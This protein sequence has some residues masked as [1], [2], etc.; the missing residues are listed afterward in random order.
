MRSSPPHPYHPIP[1]P[2]LVPRLPVTAA[3]PAS[4]PRRH[5][6]P[7]VR[8]RPRRRSLRDCS[9]SRTAASL[10]MPRLRLVRRR[11]T[12]SAPP[13]PWTMASWESPSRA[14]ARPVSPATSPTLSGG[15]VFETTMLTSTP[16]M[17]RSAKGRRRSADPDILSR[18]WFASSA[19]P[20][21]A[22]TLGPVASAFSICALVRQWRQHRPPGTGVADATFVTDPPW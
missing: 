17:A 3:G 14:R 16:G 5:P 21:I 13:P 4:M 12:P 20:M 6:T 10:L 15:L 1:V 11:P 9:A 2:D 19:F 18:W 7:V 22:G 8:S